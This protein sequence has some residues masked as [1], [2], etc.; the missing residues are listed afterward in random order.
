MRLGSGVAQ[1]GGRAAGADRGDQAFS[2][3]VTLGS[4]RKTSAPFSRAARNSSRCVAVTVAPSC[5]KARKC[6]SSGAGR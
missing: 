3:A 2:V 5:S 4:S 1:I 6:V